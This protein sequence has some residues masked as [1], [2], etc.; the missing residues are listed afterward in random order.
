MSTL[1]NTLEQLKQA[2]VARADAA[3]AR[4]QER[5]ASHAAERMRRLDL[6]CALLGETE[7][8]ASLHAA[9]EINIGAQEYS[10]SNND[11]QSVVSFKLPEHAEIQARFVFESADR[12][13]PKCTDRWEHKGFLSSRGYEYTYWTDDP[14]KMWR[15][16]EW[17]GTRYDQEEDTY[18]PA[19]R[20]VEFEDL[21]NALLH[22]E[23]AWRDPAG[24]LR[25][26]EDH[27]RKVALTSQNPDAK[28]A[29]EPTAAETLLVALERYIYQQIQI[30]HDF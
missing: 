17:T 1:P 7:P 8:F 10:H 6:L 22:A 21:G 26:V 30:A 2:A 29:P 14:E 11:Y 5:E 12:Q 23:R 18:Y 16:S 3:N 25:E 4:A 13:D 28:P 27:N 20:S 15:V 9:S 24:I 19:Y